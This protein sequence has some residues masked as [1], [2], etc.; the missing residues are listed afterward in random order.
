MNVN[1][2]KI[3]Y[4][5]GRIYAKNSNLTKTAKA[6]NITKQSFLNKVN[7]KGKFNQEEIKKLIEL[8]NIQDE[9]IAKYFFK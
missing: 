8:L 3:N 4:L 5:K 1:G 2:E 6:L 7:G 9:E